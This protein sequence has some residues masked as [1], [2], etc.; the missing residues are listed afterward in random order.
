MLQ[1][2]DRRYPPSFQNLRMA[3]FIAEFIAESITEYTTTLRD[4]S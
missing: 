2:K 4:R 1:V 3:F